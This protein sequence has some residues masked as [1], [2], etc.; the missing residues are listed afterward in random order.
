MVRLRLLFS[1]AAFL[2]IGLL[3][4]LHTDP[5]KAQPTPPGTVPAPLFLPLISSGK[6][7][8][9][10]RYLSIPIDGPPT[11]RPAALHGDLNLALRGYTPTVAALTLVDIDGHTDPDAPQLDTIFD[12]PRLPTITAVFRVHDWDWD[13]GADGCRGAPISDPPVTLINVATESGEPLT[14]PWR[15]PEVHGGGFLAMVLY[16]D[17]SRLTLVYTRHDTAAGGYV[18]HLEDIQVDP[19]L[20]A[21]YEATNQAGRSRL[22]AL[23]FGER[24]GYAAGPTIKIAIRDTGSFM[25][26]RSRKDW[27]M[28]YLLMAQQ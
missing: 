12:P 21:L 2:W 28:G 10:S 5:L 9:P 25:D 13:C 20:V 14:I 22:P 15:G 26:P 18:V 8:T 16:A 1:I 6:V 17:V 4:V 24:I 3:A 19:D 11:D 27:W 7:L 23:K